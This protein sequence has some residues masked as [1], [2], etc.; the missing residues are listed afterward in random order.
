MDAVIPDILPRFGLPRDVPVER[1]PTGHINWTYRIAGSRP[2][3]LQKL[4]TQVFV[5]PDAIESNLRITGAYLRAHHP[6]FRFVAPLPSVDG[7]QMVFDADGQPWRLFEYIANTFTIDQAENI[8]QAFQAAAEFGR[9]GHYLSQVDVTQIQPTI[10]RFHD[11][12]WR[13]QQLNEA[14]R[15]ST[16]QRREEAHEAISAAQRHATLVDRYRRLIDEGT[17]RLGVFHNDT[18]I[19]NVLFDAT[20][21]KTVAVIDLDTMMPG[22]FIYDLG[23]LVRTLV[24]P[25]SEEEQDLSQVVFRKPFYDAVVDGYMTAMG[26]A[27]SKQEKQHASFAGPMMTYIMA[28]RFLADFLRGDTYYHTTYPGQNLVRARNQLRLVDLLVSHE[29]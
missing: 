28:I 4:N 16:P 22:Y 25:V 24:S 9:L 11:L 29:S 17:L 20:T 10:D 3:I 19:N 1:I 13:Y 12:P 23:D 2:Y 18:K 21:Q 6:D 5:R 14:L 7:T 15:G 26:T 27:C 8:D